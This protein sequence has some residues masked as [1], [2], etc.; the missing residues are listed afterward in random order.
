MANRTKD[1][2]FDSLRTQQSVVPTFN[3]K[4][5]VFDGNLWGKKQRKEETKYFMVLFLK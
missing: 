3:E 5:T 1:N 4:K 2:A